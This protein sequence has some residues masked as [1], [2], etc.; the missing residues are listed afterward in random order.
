MQEEHDSNIKLIKKYKNRRL[1]DLA[2]SQYVTVE[3][4][5]N[6][7]LEDVEFR[8]IDATN[9]KDLTNA[10]L[11]QIFVELE[12]HSAQALSSNVL[13]QLIKLSKHPMSKQ[14]KDMLEQMLNKIQDHLHP[15][16]Q[17][18]QATTEL[19]MK[20]SEEFRKSWQDWLNKRDEK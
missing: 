8:V 17:G 10:T 11:L 16:V 6:Y 18:V 13:R 1:Y 4:L 2:R 3:D 14:Y 7:V 9:G 19:W 20:Q 15:Y 12:S 5:Q